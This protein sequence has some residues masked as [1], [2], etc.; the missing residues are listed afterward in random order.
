MTDLINVE[1]GGE[2]IAVHPH[3]LA[4]HEALGW[5]RCMEDQQHEEVAEATEVPTEQP[6]RRGRP[7]KAKE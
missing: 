7:P 4:Q 2:R 1:K 3:T 5:V 6:K